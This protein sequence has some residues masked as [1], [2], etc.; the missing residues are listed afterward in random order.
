MLISK[1]NSEN[2]SKGLLNSIVCDEC[3]DKMKTDFIYTVGIAVNEKNNKNIL[4]CEHCALE[5][6]KMVNDIIG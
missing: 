4:L 1:I 3:G 5:F 2:V 6:K